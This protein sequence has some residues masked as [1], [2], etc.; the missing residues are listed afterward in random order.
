[1]K[2]SRPMKNPFPG[3]RP[4]ETDEYRLFFGREGQADE[5]ISRLSR[6]RFLAVVGTSGS[7]KSSL[8]RAGLM[9]A[10][11]GG[12]MKGAGSGWRIAV[13][14]PGGN[15]I[16]NLATE[17]ARKDVLSE[18]GMGLSPEE[19]EAIIEA[20]LRSG[21]LGI[22]NVARE[23]RLGEHEKLLLVVDQ[24]EELFRFRATHEGGSVDE[25][26]AFVK[27]LLEAAQ[28]RELSV[29]IVLTM[30]S[31]FLGD[32]AQFQGLP[33]AINDGQYLIP[34]MTRDERRFAVTGPVG[35]TRGKISEPLINRLLND[36]GDNPDQLPIL[37]H[38]LMRT[39]EHWQA[40]RRDSEPIGLEH[41]EAIGTMS[42]ALSRHADEAFN[43][44][45]DDRSR[46]IA[47]VLFKALSERGADNREI[48]R[49]TR[50]STICEITGASV[51]EVI[52]VIDVF[53]RGG[54][55][56]LM[57]PMGT[58]L[59]ADSVI[60][61]S[62]ESLIRNWQRLK[63]W[64]NEEGQ[65]VRVY[66]RVAETAV[67][68]RE[69][70]EGLMQDP[71]L[72]FALDWRDKSHPTKAWGERYHPDFETAMTYLEQSRLAREERLAAEE[73]KRQEEIERDKR[74]LEQTKLFVAQQARA[75]RRMRVLLV[76]M[77]VI[78]LLSIATAAFAWNQRSSALHSREA[79][80]LARKNAELSAEAARHA[81]SYAQDQA[82]AAVNSKEEAL[83]AQKVAADEKERAEA[84]AKLATEQKAQAEENLHAAQIAT[85]KANEATIEAQ[86]SAQQVASALERGELIRSGLE[87]YRREDYNLARSSFEKL[88]EKLRGLQP[89]A[90]G[91]QHFTPQ[92]ARQ[93][94]RDYGWTM[95]RLGATYHQ[96]RDFEKAIE[97][98]EKSRG[99]LE[100]LLKDEPAA[101]LFE[102]YH[103]LAR[104]YH[105]NATELTSGRQVS[106]NPDSYSPAEQLTKA[107]EYYKK[108]ATYQQKIESDNPLLTVG[109]LKNLAQLY[110]DIGRYDDAEQSLKAV[111]DAYKTVEY[112][113]GA[114]VEGALKEFAEFYRNRSRFEDALRTY[115]EL[116]E[117]YE[118]AVNFYNLEP[119]RIREL[120]D[121]YSELGQIYIAMKDEDRGDAAFELVKTIQ[122][123]QLKLKKRGP[124]SPDDPAATFD[125]DLDHMGDIYIK[126]GRVPQARRSYEKAL[127]IREGVKAEN[128]SLAISYLKLANLYRDEYKDYEKAEIYYKKLIENRRNVKGNLFGPDDPLAQYVT[129]LRQ[130]AT[131]YTNDLSKLT[132]AE[133]LLNQALAALKPVQGRLAW[134]DEG[135]IYDDLINL[136]RKQQKDGQPMYVQKLAAM[137]ARRD[138]FRSLLRSP[139][140]QHFAYP[141]AQTAGEVADLYLKQNNKAAALEAYAQ[142][143]NF[144]SISVPTPDPKKLDNFLTNL[145]KY[146]SL[147]RENKDET[148][149][150]KFDET[151]RRGRIR[152]KELES[153][154][155]ETQPNPQ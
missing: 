144:I 44:L 82:V 128:G 98:Y 108:A 148:L 90:N 53:R 5:L 39:W 94:S 49:P 153:I 114:G 93:A 30:R 21:S 87:A 65:S 73:K 35:V 141:Y 137:T 62:H 102:T 88:E 46:K 29:Y 143:F 138:A 41:Y 3:L 61:I 84:A 104:A 97:H 129:G 74:E 47:E 32:C 83:E 48:R 17:L 103:G 101:I 9:P 130:L 77:C 118:N 105:D 14:R 80:E 66:R 89:G 6:S 71:A 117:L 76:A 20:T 106:T 75:A 110:L 123:L 40:N 155:Q 51:A 56:F 70:G 42:D 16:G 31:D 92:Q 34:R 145:E 37:Q 150:A 135:A 22:L 67:L 119:Q 64:V 63:D 112:Y 72:S 8:I 43:E 121:N 115:S 59:H 109:S 131:L 52:A 1:M 124:L 38:A 116:I 26:S 54:R 18:A 96:L 91:P 95:S 19:A 69:G 139:E 36:V 127:E 12:M 152:Q 23:A 24:F 81:E 86:R 11:R 25:A 13:M 151:V 125:D 79:A 132:E 45:P 107:E 142:V 154:Q 85:A 147:L 122:S 111:V 149:A 100:P 120:A 99:I 7:G 55:S 60:D 126:L 4:F 2:Q 50:L 28:Q 140:Y 27:L 57:P 133:A 136:Y 68:H 134:D 58:E 78:L 113:P 15:P 33:E 10:L 146:Q